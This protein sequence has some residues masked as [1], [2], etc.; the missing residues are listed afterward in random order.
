MARASKKQQQILKEGFDRKYI[1]RLEY[2]E[3]LQDSKYAYEVVG[4]I[5]DLHRNE[6]FHQIRIMAMSSG[7]CDLF[8]DDDDDNYGYMNGIYCAS[9]M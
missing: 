4:R 8:Y 1:D 9:D 5:F 2:E 3:A 7:D 6:S